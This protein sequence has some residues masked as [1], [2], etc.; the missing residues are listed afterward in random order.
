MNPSTSAS[1]KTSLLLW[2]IGVVVFLGCAYS[3]VG[4]IRTAQNTGI[5]R[6]STS[7]PAAVLSISRSGYGAQ[8]I[9]RGDTSIHLVPGT[10]HVAA[11][12]EGKEFTKVVRVNIGQT[13]VAKVELKN[14]HTLPSVDGIDFQN[15]DALTSSGI[16]SSQLGVLKRQLFTFKPLA[17]HI[18]INSSTVRPA[19]HNIATD[20]G[21]FKIGFSLSVDSKPYSA[22]ISY[23][24][25]SN[26][27][28]ILTDP[29]TKNSVFQAESTN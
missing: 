4:A 27:K 25:L 8:I 29:V 1:H 18:I 10:Y 15:F 16:T 28:L 2:L 3:V 21:N 17:K 7:S 12:L 13:T 20:G 26:V 14:T 11:T 9:G 19:P 23:H 22:I 5:L 6:V 24:D